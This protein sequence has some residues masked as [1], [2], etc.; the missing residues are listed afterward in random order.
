M[1]AERNKCCI[2]QQEI[3]NYSSKMSD[4]GMEFHYYGGNG[5][6]R[7]YCMGCVHKALYNLEQSDGKGNAP[8]GGHEP[9]MQVEYVDPRDGLCPECN[10]SFNVHLVTCSKFKPYR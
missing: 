5:K 7:W 1:S 2:C 4:N 10:C 6:R 3:R 9:V 8:Q